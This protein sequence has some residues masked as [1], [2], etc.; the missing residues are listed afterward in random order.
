MTYRVHCP[1]APEMDKTFSTLE[2]ARPYH[3]AL[4]RAGYDVRIN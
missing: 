1:N 2:S 4:F 3:A